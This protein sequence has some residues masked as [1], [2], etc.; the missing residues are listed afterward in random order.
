MV[1]SQSD[2]LSSSH[3]CVQMWELDYKENWAWNN[4][5]FQTAVLE[6]ILESPL[7]SNEIKLVNLKGNQPWIFT[8][9]TDAKAEAPILWPP[10]VKN[11]LIGKDPD[12]GK[13]WRQEEKGT[14]KDEVIGCYHWVIGHEFEK[15]LEDGDG[16]ESMAC[17]SPWGREQSGVT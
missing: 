1:C 12:A 13:D 9:R 14:T 16:Q 3:V 6:K 17:C 11:W 10:D 2:G 15:T 8:R 7:V 5:C 4:S